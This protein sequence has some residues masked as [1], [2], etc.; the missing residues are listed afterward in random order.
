MSLADSDLRVG[1]V[2][3]RRCD[4]LGIVLAKAYMT[5]D[6]EA[7]YGASHLQPTPDCLP[8]ACHRLANAL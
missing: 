1:A 6:A 3:A 5:D 7:E 8:R 2:R 4:R